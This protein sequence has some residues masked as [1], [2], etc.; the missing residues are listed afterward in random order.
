MEKV[1]PR[2]SASPPVIAVAAGDCVATDLISFDERDERRATIRLDRDHR[3]LDC[4]RTY[5]AVVESW[6]CDRRRR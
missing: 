3:I 4:D 1:D 2:G 5:S 6:R